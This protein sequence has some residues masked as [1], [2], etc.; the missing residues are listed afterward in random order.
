LADDYDEAFS[1]LKKAESKSCLESSDSDKNPHPSKDFLKG[2]EDILRMTKSWRENIPDRQKLSLENRQVSI[3]MY[4][5]KY[6][7]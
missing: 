5:P 1:K 4:V 6:Y 3:L 2:I 7:N